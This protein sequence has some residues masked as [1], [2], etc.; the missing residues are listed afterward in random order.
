MRLSFIRINFDGLFMSVDFILAILV[1]ILVLF[2]YVN[3][4]VIKVNIEKVSIFYNRMDLLILILIP[5]LLYV[6]STSLNL[7]YSNSKESWL[8]IQGPVFGFI[9]SLLYILY[10]ELIHRLKKDRLLYFFII[11]C[12]CATLISFLP[13]L[14]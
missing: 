7:E 8:L 10:I 14:F 3:S 5:L 2:F 11:T 6:L 4:P 13:M 12:V 9:L 1:V